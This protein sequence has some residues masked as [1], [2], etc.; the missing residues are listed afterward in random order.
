[1]AT[2]FAFGISLTRPPISPSRWPTTAALVILEDDRAIHSGTS[3]L[4]SN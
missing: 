2:P 3:L 4:C 1:V